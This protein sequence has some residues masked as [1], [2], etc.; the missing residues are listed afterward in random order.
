MALQFKLQLVVVADDDEQ[1][2]VDELVVLNKDYERLAQ[3]GLTLAEAKALL[4][5]L[6]RQVLTGQ[7]AA[8]LAP[9]IWCRPVVEA[10]ASRIARPSCSAPYSASWSR[11]ARGSVAVRAGTAGWRPPVR[12]WSCRPSTP[13]LSCCS[14]RAVGIPDLL[15]ADGHSRSHRPPEPSRRDPRR[16]CRLHL[17]TCRLSAAEVL[18]SVSSGGARGAQERG[19]AESLLSPLALG[20]RCRDKAPY[21][22][23]SQV[24]R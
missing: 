9:R 14:W 12:W 15:W 4:L 1:V 11:P 19:G 10:A 13:H 22:Q 8:F 6:Q 7:I 3:L 5:E 24:R 16:C 18:P 2:S 20:R 17:R 21:L 23:D